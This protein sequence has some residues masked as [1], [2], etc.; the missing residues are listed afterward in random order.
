V[1]SW[2]QTYR[3]SMSRPT[4]DTTTN[5][6]SIAA[7]EEG[8]SPWDG[9]PPRILLCCLYHYPHAHFQLQTSLHDPARATT[10]PRQ[11]KTANSKPVY[12]PVAMKEGHGLCADAQRRTRTTVPTRGHRAS[13]LSQCIDRLSQARAFEV[14]WPSTTCQTHTVYDPRE[15]GRF[16]GTARPAWS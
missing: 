16:V 9:K 14:A 13:T 11:Q 10:L 5:P 15:P 6:W 8:G 4:P 1:V 2:S 7:M 12:T 3:A